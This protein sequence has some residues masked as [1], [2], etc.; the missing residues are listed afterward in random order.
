MFGTGM[1]GRSRDADMSF[2]TCVST[3]PFGYKFF[4]ILSCCFI[5]FCV[6]SISYVLY[7]VVYPAGYTEGEFHFWNL[8]TSITV[9]STG[10]MSIPAVLISFLWLYFMMPGL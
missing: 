10:W 3:L 7:N 9:S 4:F 5:P 1:V 2:S 8:I 6:F